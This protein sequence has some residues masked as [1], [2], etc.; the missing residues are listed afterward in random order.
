MK[1]HFSRKHTY[2]DNT[3]YLFLL[4]L[5]QGGYCVRIKALHFVNTPPIAD[6]LIGMIKVAF[7]SKIAKRV[8]IKVSSHFSN[9]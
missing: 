3:Y 9:A 7:K 4:C 6:I 8:S 2:T 5:F 1:K